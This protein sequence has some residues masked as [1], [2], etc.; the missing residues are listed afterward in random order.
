MQVVCKN[1]Q[2][3]NPAHMQKIFTFG[4]V[5][6]NFLE[7]ENKIK[8]EDC[9]KKGFEKTRFIGLYLF[10]CIATIFTSRKKDEIAIHGNFFIT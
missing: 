1:A 3:S 4:L 2:L 10:W 8:T 6:S 7:V 9:P 5:G